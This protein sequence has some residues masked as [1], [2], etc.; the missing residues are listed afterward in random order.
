MTYRYTNFYMYLF[1]HGYTRVIRERERE[2]WNLRTSTIIIAG[3]SAFG[4]KHVDST[5]Y[6]QKIEHS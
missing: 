6:C 2:R 1:K 5:K 4:S 3:S